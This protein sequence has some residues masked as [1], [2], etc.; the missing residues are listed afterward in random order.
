M[1]YPRAS[2]KRLST[3]VALVALL[4]IT[5]LFVLAGPA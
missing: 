3:V 4:A 2:S 5:A 1:Q